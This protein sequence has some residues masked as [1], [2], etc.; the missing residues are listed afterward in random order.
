MKK[1]KPII[2][3]LVFLAL[4]IVTQ[5]FN[6]YNYSYY[7]EEQSLIN[8]TT[9]GIA[10][11]IFI[12]V[13]GV[14]DVIV[15][16]LS[17]KI[18]FKNGKRKT[19]IS[20]FSPVFALFLVLTF[21]VD[22]NSGFSPVGFFIYYLFITISFDNFSSVLYI[23]Y[24]SMFPVVFR[25][26]KTREKAAPLNHLFEM[27][28]IG[29]ALLFSMF[30]IPHIGYVWTSVIFAVIF[31]LIIYFVLPHIHENEVYS[32]SD[33]RTKFSSRKALKE[34]I[35]EKSFLFFNLANATFLAIMSCAVTIFPMVLKYVF[36]LESI[37]DQ[38]IAT[39]PILVS[40]LLSMRLWAWILQKKGPR[41]SYKLSFILLPIGILLI[42]A[43]FNMVSTCIF[44]PLGLPLVV[45]ALITPD[46]M[47]A[48]LI[49]ADRA[50]YHEHREAAIY[51]LNSLVKRLAMLVIVA[52]IMIVAACFGYENGNNP[53]PHPEMTFRIIIT[54]V[55]PIV[56][57]IGT[58]F[59][60]IFLR[61]F[62][63]NDHSST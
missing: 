49:D 3:A 7:V 5:F 4:S 58:L 41:F 63:N 11:I 33:T 12:I 40:L 37:S 27:G 32:E 22:H 54:V 43:S 10:K 14:N 9:A 35:K 13:D 26:E 18:S 48:K 1:T 59:S 17:D 57:A 60:L 15:G 19:W 52:I 47:L 44:A 2:F 8:F 38:I 45:G 30:L 6:F 36:H 20:Y 34:I 62:P 55:L 29:F 25:D 28:G 61:I 42:S 51:S 24:N 21:V 46:L 16:F 53:G 31:L 23:N 50:S 39:I 56:G